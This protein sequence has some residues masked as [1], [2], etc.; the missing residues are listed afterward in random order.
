MGWVCALNE[1]T[2]MFELG[3]CYDTTVIKKVMGNLSESDR[4][5]PGQF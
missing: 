2:V 1:G 4:G 3:L 5:V